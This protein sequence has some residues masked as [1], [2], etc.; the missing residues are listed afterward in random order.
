M[1][2]THMLLLLRTEI[3]PQ[4]DTF[5]RGERVTE[6]VLCPSTHKART[7]LTMQWSRQEHMNHRY[8]LSLNTSFS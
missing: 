7:I 3:E 8:L 6:C 1:L 4:A 2:L 5:L